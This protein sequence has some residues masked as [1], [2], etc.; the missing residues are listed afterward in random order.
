M[1]DTKIELQRNKFDQIE[2]GDK[3]MKKTNFLSKAAVF[4]ALMILFT[5]AQQARAQSVF[6]DTTSDD[7]SLTAC[8][9][10]PNDCSLR[11]AIKNYSKIEFE[12][13]SNDLG[14]TSQG[15]CTITL[16]HGMISVIRGNAIDTVSIVNATGP[17]KLIISGNNQSSVF[18]NDKSQ[19][20]L[21]G[22][23]IANGKG[24]QHGIGTNLAGGI[25]TA[26]NGSLF[27]KNCIVIDNESSTTAGGIAS[28]GYGWID[29]STIINNSGVNGGVA[30]YGNGLQIQKSTISGNTAFYGYGNGGG[31]ALLGGSASIHNSTISGNTALRGAGIYFSRTDPSATSPSLSLYNSTITNNAATLTSDTSN[32]GGI[33]GVYTDAAYQGQRVPALLSST[34]V[35]GNHNANA[36]DVWAE[37]KTDSAYNLI[38][39]GTGLTDSSGQTTNQIGTAANPIDPLLGPLADNGGPTHTHALSPGSPA[40]DQGV[41][42]DYSASTTHLSTDQRGLIR[43]ADQPSVSNAADGTD[44]GAYEALAT[45]CPAITLSPSTLPN[46]SVAFS[47][48]QTVSASGGSGP[49]TFSV[50]NGFLPYGLSLN[51]SS[52]VVSGTPDNHG[53]FNFTV[54]AR[55][56]NGCSGAQAYT[57]NIIFNPPSNLQAESIGASFVKL[58]WTDNTRHEIGFVIQICGDTT[59]KSGAAYRQAGANATT[60]TV[61]QLSAN[62][63]YVFRVA[64]VNSAGEWSAFSNYITVKTR[65]R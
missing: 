65:I 41:K 49:Y 15:V 43:T 28:Y 13:P 23:T 47:Y 26:V 11:G 58:R 19:L 34:I 16:T 36:P 51:Q 40:I 17:G 45:P 10:A 18:Y 42:V 12:I 33:Q 30:S 8:T 14:C 38:G 2:S 5:V 56:Y 48:N 61:T 54:T 62:T 27:I 25:T 3:A 24:H 29:N 20:W 39:D 31:I 32:A 55:D 63:Q 53:S 22:I 21:D 35:A 1:K 57:V 6:V 52:G 50:T 44:I 64:A 9:S 60:F 59:C 7:S 37:M 46:G 4:F